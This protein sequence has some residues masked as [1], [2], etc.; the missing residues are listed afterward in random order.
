MVFC[1]TSQ[2]LPASHALG[3]TVKLLPQGDTPNGEKCKDAAEQWVGS[4]KEGETKG[5]TSMHGFGREKCEDGVEGQELY[6][7]AVGNDKNHPNQ[8]EWPRTVS[9]SQSEG[10]D[11]LRM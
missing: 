1:S 4:W 3:E 6:K 2:A 7:A 10:E 9:H 8:P 11:D 5:H